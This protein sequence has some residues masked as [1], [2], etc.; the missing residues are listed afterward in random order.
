MMVLI[1]AASNG[2]PALSDFRIFFSEKKKNLKSD[3]A[4]I[5]TYA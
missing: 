2:E 5:V 3:N 4:S 1:E